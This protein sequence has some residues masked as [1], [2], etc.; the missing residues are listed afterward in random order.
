MEHV[1]LPKVIAVGI[2]G[3]AES[4]RALAWALA[5]AVGTGAHLVVTHGSGML[6][7]AGL[8]AG[9]DLEAALADAAEAAA[10]DIGQLTAPPVLAARPGH[11]VEVLMAV[12][13][14]E[15]VDLLIVGRRGV[16]GNRSTLGSTSEAIL[17]ASSVPVV[18]F[19]HLN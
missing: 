17:R 7:G 12:A 10:V 15:G 19:P 11:P 2:D 3:S 9:V 4:T 13:G 1:T 6:E 18:V 14:E 8:L 5:L 16:G